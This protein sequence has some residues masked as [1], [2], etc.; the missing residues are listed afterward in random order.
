MRTLVFL[1][2][3]VLFTFSSCSPART[4]NRTTI[5]Q[6]LEG[7]VQIAR[8]D[9]MPSPDL[10]KE[11]PAGYPTTVYIHELTPLAQLRKTDQSGLFLSVP[12]PLITSVTTDS[13]GRFSIALSPGNY[14]LFVK[15]KNGF[16]ANW[17]NEKNQVGPAEVQENKITQLKL[18]ITAEATF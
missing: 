9:R 1:F 13:V 15:Y 16:Y 2:I 10:P 17:F 8:G 7:V 5:R 18:L 4:T 6:G 3:S 12:T 14:S 11:E